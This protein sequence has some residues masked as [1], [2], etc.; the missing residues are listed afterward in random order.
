[1]FLFAPFLSTFFWLYHQKVVIRK[2]V[3]QQLIAGLDEEELVKLTFSKE[4]SRQLDWKHAHE[5][6]YQ[7]KMF[8]V[9]K[10][11]LHGANISYWCWPD[12]QE[13][14][15]NKALTTLVN[16]VLGHSRQSREHQKKLN[17]FLK[18]LFNE[19]QQAWHSTLPPPLQIA[20]SPYSERTKNLKLDQL[21]P[22]PVVIHS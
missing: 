21:S 9:V 5:F 10:S 18:T 14:Q 20:F 3:K 8:D 17:Q 2:E 4:A 11:R 12:R 7:G 15:L 1:M 6:E 13:T 19:T 16:K 22:P